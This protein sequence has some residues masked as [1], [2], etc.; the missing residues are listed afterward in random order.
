MLYRILPGHTFRVDDDTVKGAGEEI[1]LSEDTARL[2]AGK[3]E[4][5]DPE[6]HI[7]EEP[8]AQ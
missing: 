6:A 5:V 2:H 1:E 7:A 8:A 4:P 3:V